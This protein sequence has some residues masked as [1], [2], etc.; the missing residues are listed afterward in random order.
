MDSLTQTLLG[1]LRSPELPTALG[2]VADILDLVARYADEAAFA[3]DQD[4]VAALAVAQLCVQARAALP[5]SPRPAGQGPGLT[6]AAGL[7]D[8]LDAATERLDALGGD[9]PPL[10]A[11]AE[12]AA[13]AS[14]AL[15]KILNVEG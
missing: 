2:A 1:D 5:L 4:E 14:R 3:P 9:V 13:K 12:D 8:L 7:P 6:A 10:R 15:R 11:P